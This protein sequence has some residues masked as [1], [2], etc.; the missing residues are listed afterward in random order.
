[1]QWAEGGPDPARTLQPERTLWMILV[2]PPTRSRLQQIGW[3]HWEP[4]QLRSLE[5]IAVQMP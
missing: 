3:I 4:K 1:M 5:E 2:I